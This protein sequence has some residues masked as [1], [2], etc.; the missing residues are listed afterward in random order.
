[1]TR[2]RMVV[3]GR[4]QSEHKHEDNPRPDS[5]RF[6]AVSTAALLCYP[7]QQI[8]SWIKPI[9][10]GGSGM[11]LLP[12]AWSAWVPRGGPVLWG[13]HPSLPPPPPTM[14]G[15]NPDINKTRSVLRHNSDNVCLAKTN[16]SLTFRDEVPLTHFA[17]ERFFARVHA[18]VDLE[19]PYVVETFPAVLTTVG[20]LQNRIVIRGGAPQTR[21]KYE[22]ARRA[23]ARRH[24]NPDAQ[25][26]FAGPQPQNINTSLV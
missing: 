24:L 26:S 1:M 2:T 6:H 3:A 13:V 5:A 21:T 12:L 17:L 14:C 15:K 23:V 11:G 16:D 4:Y 10:R 9:Q 22:K 20:K 19:R 25:F 18:D 8:Y 7:P